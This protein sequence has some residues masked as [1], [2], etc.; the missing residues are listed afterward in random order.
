MPTF[1]GT[2]ALMDAAGR[3]ASDIAGRADALDWNRR[4]WS[5]RFSE[6]DRIVEELKLR[7]NDHGQDSGR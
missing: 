4:L 2:R 3:S 7:E 1:S 6:L 5:A